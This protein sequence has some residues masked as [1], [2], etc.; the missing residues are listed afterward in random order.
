MKEGLKSSM[1]Y[2]IYFKNI[3]KCHNEP[4]PSTIKKKKGWWGTDVNIPLPKGV[5]GRSLPATPSLP[6]GPL[7]VQ[8]LD[9]LNLFGRGWGWWSTPECYSA[10]PAGVGGWGIMQSSQEGWSLDERT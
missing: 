9:W 6:F 1:M 10:V 3:C 8:A 7:T 5:L 4:P 2:L